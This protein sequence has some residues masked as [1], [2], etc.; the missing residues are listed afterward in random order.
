MF[1]FWLSPSD[2][3][4]TPE[5]VANEVKVSNKTGIPPGI[6]ISDDRMGESL[7]ERLKLLKKPEVPTNS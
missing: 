1:L 6:L 2:P 3:L 5:G 4:L 7:R